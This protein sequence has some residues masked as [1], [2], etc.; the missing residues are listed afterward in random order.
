MSGQPDGN[1]LEMLVRITDDLRSLARKIGSVSDEGSKDE[2]AEASAF[3]S[4]AEKASPFRAELGKRGLRREPGPSLPDKYLLKRM[5]RYRGFRV[6]IFGDK[7]FTDPAW[8]MVLDL[9]LARLEHRRVS[10]TSLCIASRV[11]ATT[12]LRWIGVLEQEGFFV[13]SSDE[14]DRRRSFI[15]LSEKGL[16]LVAKYF[17]FCGGYPECAAVA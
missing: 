9:A 13:R 4:L 15:E 6:E 1:A 17:D 10:I 2:R 11:P 14:L 7:L 16:R 8:D 12:A 5:I 3:P